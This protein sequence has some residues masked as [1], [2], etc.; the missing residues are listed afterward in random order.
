MGFPQVAGS[1]LN[2]DSFLMH[3]APS[4]LVLH[5]ET[6]LSLVTLPLFSLNPAKSRMSLYYSMTI[7]SL[8]MYSPIAIVYVHKCFPFH[9]GFRILNSKVTIL[10]FLCCPCIFAVSWCHWKPTPAW[11]TQSSMSQRN[12]GKHYLKLQK[13]PFYHISKQAM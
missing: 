9:W 5:S 11:V 8:S 10:Y 4:H 12:K 13:M 1:I 7:F 6:I 3:L 2:A